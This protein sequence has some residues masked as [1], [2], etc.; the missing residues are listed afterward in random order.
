M[1]TAGMME[2]GVGLPDSTGIIFTRGMLPCCAFELLS[3][4]LILDFFLK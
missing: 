4:R 2:V 3:E 1:A